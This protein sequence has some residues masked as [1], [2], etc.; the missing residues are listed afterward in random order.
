MA[1]YMKVLTMRHKGDPC[2]YHNKRVMTLDPWFTTYWVQDYKHFKI[3]LKRF[4]FKDIAYE[5]WINGTG[6]EVPTQMKWITDVDHLYLIH[7]TG[8]NH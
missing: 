8:G 6:G 1:A 3:K 7:Q 4:S 2:P 5:Q